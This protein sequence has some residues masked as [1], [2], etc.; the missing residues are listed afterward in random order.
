MK[1]EKEPIYGYWRLI[2]GIVFFDLCVVAGVAA[3]MYMGVWK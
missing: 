2:G 1:E 3:A